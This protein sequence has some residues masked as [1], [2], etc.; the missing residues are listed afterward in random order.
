MK[1][2][3]IFA[4]TLRAVV[5]ENELMQLIQYKPI[6]ETVLDR[7]LVIVPP[8]I[9]NDYI[10]KNS[11]VKYAV[12]QG[13]TVFVISWVNPEKELSDVG[14]DNYLTD[15]VFKA[16]EIV[17]AITCAEKVNTSSWCIG[18]TLLAT[19]LAVLPEKSGNSV[20]SAT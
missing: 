1:V 4:I 2:G 16:L 8:Y 18:G 17:K 19:A 6:T 10:P 13:N 20:A 5:Y 12:D 11:F 14:W 7:P 3:K 9:N 15:G